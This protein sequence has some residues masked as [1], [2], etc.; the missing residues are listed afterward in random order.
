[1]NIKTVK[2]LTRINTLRLLRAV[3]KR[4]YQKVG[5]LDAT[6]VADNEPRA[7]EDR[8][9]AQFKHIRPGTRWSDVAY[10]S[11]WFHFTGTIP[12]SAR[13][14]HVAF[15]ISL[16]AEGCVVDNNGTPVQGLAVH[17][18][19]LEFL[20]NPERGKQ[21]V[22]FKKAAEGGEKV[23]FWVE[24]GNNKF[25]RSNLPPPKATFKRANIVI[26]RDD[27]KAFYYDISV[28]SMQLSSIDKDKFPDKH[29]SLKRMFKKALYLCRPFTVESVAAARRAIKTESEQGVP[30]EYTVYATGHAHLDL[31]WL[32]P[33]RETKRKAGRTFANALRYIE[34]YDDYIF[35]ASQPQQFA[36]VEEKYPELFKQLQNA[37]ENNKIELQGLMWVE[38]DMNV[39]SGESIIRQSLY[40]KRYWSQK[41][42]KTTKIC[43]LPDIFGFN[44]NLPQFIKKCGMEYFLT[45]KLSW[46]VY[47][48]FPK[49]TFL[50][51][52]ID[53]SQVLAHMPPEDNYVSDATPMDL[54][55]AVKNY[56]E[57][58]K[59]KVFSM[60]YGIG[61]GG[62][63]PGERHIETA[64]RDGYFTGV[65]KVIM[66]PASKLFEELEKLRSSLD[67]YKGELYLEK[68]QGTYTSQGRNKYFN[69]KIE[70]LIHNIEFLYA[71]TNIPYPYKEM[72]V[73]WKEILLYQFHD[74]IPGSSIRRVYTESLAR[75]ETICDKL[76]EI[77]DKALEAL[78]RADGSLTCI[79]PTSFRLKDIVNYKGI[80][81]SVDVP[82]YGAG[83]LEEYVPTEKLVRAEG[84]VVETDKFVVT[85]APSGEISSL[86][87]KKYKEEYVGEFFNKL[88]VY[89]DKGKFY[90]AWD[91]DINYPSRVLSTFEPISST[92]ECSDAR[93]IKETT[94]KYQQSTI[95]QKVIMTAGKS[96]IEFETTVDWQE[97]H[98]MLRAEFKPAVFDDS[99]TCDIQMGNIKRSTR[100]ETSHEK[101]QFEICA[102]KWVD[103][104]DGDKG[105]SVFSECKY[106]W[107]IKNGLMSLNLLRST[108]HPGLDA[109]KAIH[110]FRY[111][112]YPH[113]HSVFDANTAKYA[114]QFNNKPIILENG[115]TFESLLSTSEKNIVIETI[116]PSE[117]ESG[118]IVRVYEDAGKV[119]RARLTYQKAYGR[120]YLTDML[121]NIISS[122]NIEQL[123]FTPYEIKT[124]LIK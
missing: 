86:F 75:Y 115:I 62:G 50:W 30:S 110:T 17:Y 122:V 2:Y 18:N 16:G 59:V 5:E 3:R 37:V 51:E 39:T 8:D 92:I 77:T 68:H 76:K 119:T 4:V 53:G 93:A 121:E 55:Y 60:L 38:P 15:M 54:S 83:L 1:M 29:A 19:A 57:K 109:D 34:R 123:I 117:D 94:Y 88:V 124:I 35:G 95:I 96:Y 23:D 21:I 31:A 12:A 14:K 112:I 47:N 11:A 9:K 45:I 22:E 101:A 106:G 28:L 46:N 42:N 82:P 69:N 72:E 78:T 102:H 56:P 48:K 91:I 33:I 85:F 73:I 107:R 89:N 64:I 81:Y 10:G 100:N 108:M 32:W 65:P 24:G 87:V 61:D 104:G 103:V 25:L 44:G 67:V 66:A 20:H 113:V 99:V 98:K 58:D 70:K 118:I 6:Y 105:L 26:V 40:G 36:W 74:I 114:Y 43:W 52:G 13:N 120:C 7:L 84:N 80:E 49:R 116:K 90:D 63:G 79:N 41:F 27:I 71:L 111:A 97:T